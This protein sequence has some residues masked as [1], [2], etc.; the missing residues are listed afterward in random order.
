M[1]KC[2]KGSREERLTEECLHTFGETLIDRMKFTMRDKQSCKQ[3]EWLHK[4]KHEAAN[5]QLDRSHS[6][7]EIISFQGCSFDK[8][9][10]GV[11]S[12]FFW[13][14]WAWFQQTA[15]SVQTHSQWRP[16]SR[17][18][19]GG[20]SSACVVLHCAPESFFRQRIHELAL[21]KQE[22]VHGR[23]R[24]WQ[25]PSEKESVGQSYFV[26]RHLLPSVSTSEWGSN[27]EHFS[28]E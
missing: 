7:C 16:A 13:W 26:S 14:D 11:P 6:S 5:C 19:K 21:R 17:R 8:S 1:V 22:C 25:Q 23:G 12:W 10:L 20:T 18:Q 27:W 15:V 24:D 9:D 4:D 2:A 3:H 28:H